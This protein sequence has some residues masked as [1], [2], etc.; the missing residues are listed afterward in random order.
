MQIVTETHATLFQ[1]LLHCTKGLTII[2]LL[3]RSR[4]QLHVGGGQVPLSQL[5]HVREG[6]ALH[7]HAGPVPRLAPHEGRHT[8]ELI[9][10]YD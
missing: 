7:G 2:H 4:L 8:G 9:I 1:P 3:P 10:N 6:G 5:R